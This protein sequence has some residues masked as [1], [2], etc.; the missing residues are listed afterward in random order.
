VDPL[1]ARINRTKIRAKELWQILAC[2][3]AA[4]FPS[5]TRPAANDRPPALLCLVDLV[6]DLDV[7]LPVMLAARDSG[8]FSITVCMTSWL[9]R[10]APWAPERLAEAGFEPIVVER[11]HLQTCENLPLERFDA[12]LTASESTT[13]AHRFGHALVK[14]ANRQGLAT[15][16]LQHGLENLG[17][18]SRVDGDHEFASK[19][20]LTWGPPAAL[21]RWVPYSR[22][23][24]CVGVGRPGMRGGEIHDLP[25]WTQGR[26]IVAVF[27]NLHWERYSPDYA[28][29]FVDDL[30]GAARAL[31]E[32]LFLIKPHPAGQWLTRN[33]GALAARPANLSVVDLG[34]AEWRRTTAADLIFHACAVVTTPSTVAL[35]AAEIGRPT[36]VAAYGLSLDAYAPLPMLGSEG[37]W[38]AF[39][40]DA[41]AGGPGAARLA[42]AFQHRHLAPGEAS[43]AALLAIDRAIP[44]RKA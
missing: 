40:K 43:E 30:M 5:P 12:L 25:P 27:E 44:R 26:P 6:Q 39:L 2:R 31:P 7:L 4:W 41:I 21:P 35:D 17:L 15:I 8:R 3:A 24:R 14:H 19:T 20:V 38:M 33:P 9:G 32:A 1:Q 28:R 23:R 22:R 10:S 18:T 34:A 36:A 13:A 37:D 11:H 42:E 29:R 16:T